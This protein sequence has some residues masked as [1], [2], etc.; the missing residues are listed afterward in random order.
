[1]ILRPPRST[2]TDTLFPD[3]TLFRSLSR[4][5]L[6]VPASVPTGQYIVSVYLIRDGA[7]VS[8]QTTPLVVSK[9]GLGADIYSY[10]QRQSAGY[11]VLAILIAVA[12]GWLAS[13]AFRRA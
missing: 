13:L 6:A 1:M 9:I 10:S 3:P 11:G 4:T 2:P 7:V 5:R 8:A 12:T